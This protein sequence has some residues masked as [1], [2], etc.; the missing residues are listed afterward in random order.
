MIIDFPFIMHVICLLY[1]ILLV[2]EGTTLMGKVYRF[3]E[4]TPYL[5]TLTC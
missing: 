4:S 1:S 3:D 2:G 5:V